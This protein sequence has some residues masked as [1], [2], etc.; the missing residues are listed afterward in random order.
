M[1]KI[2]DEK[3]KAKLIKRIVDIGE[4]IIKNADSI[5]GN[6]RYLLADGLKIEINI[7]E[8]SGDTITVSQT[9][10]PEGLVKASYRV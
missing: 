9:F 8:S 4:S 10:L 1:V 6:Y 5:A 7:S 3:T 2:M